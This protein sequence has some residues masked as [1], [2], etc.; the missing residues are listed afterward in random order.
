MKSFVFALLI[1]LNLSL[2]AEWA[3]DH[4]RYISDSIKA[5]VH[6]D[7]TLI[8]SLIISGRKYIG[9]PH[10]MGGT[11]EDCLDCSGFMF[12]ILKQQGIEIGR[13]SEQMAYYGKMITHLDSLKKGD[14]VFFKKSYNTSKYVTHVGIYTQNGFFLHA[15]AQKGVEEISFVESEYWFSRFIFAKRIFYP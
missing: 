10:C 8:D 3:P 7:T 1:I 15:S 11:G 2:R 5:A 6:F 9:K 4:N 14:L 12:K 13:D